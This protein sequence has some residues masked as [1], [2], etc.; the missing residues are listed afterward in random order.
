MKGYMLNKGFQFYTF[1]DIILEPIKDTVLNYN[2]FIT[3]CDCNHYPD[4][5]L[6]EDYIWLSGDDLLQIINGQDIQFIWAVFSAIPKENTL[7]DVLKYDFP[8]ADMN[9]GFWKN[10]VH[11][12]HPL[13]EIEIVPWDSSLVLF[14]AKDD[15]LVDVFAAN[16]PL[17]VD[18]EQYN[19]EER[20]Q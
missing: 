4:A 18:L 13:A 17:G 19:A 8:Y 1:M 14:I 3:A 9:R 7:E 10:P 6:E 11:I 20:E 15:S 5:R 2:W 16:F 12:Q